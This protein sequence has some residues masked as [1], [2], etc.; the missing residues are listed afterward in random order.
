[1]IFKKVHKP[2]N[3]YHKPSSGGRAPSTSLSILSNCHTAAA[4]VEIPQNA[5]KNITC[6]TNTSD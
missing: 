3:K 4:E 5:L 1:M 2:R 6:F